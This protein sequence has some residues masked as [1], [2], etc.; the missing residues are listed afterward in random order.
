MKAANFIITERRRTIKILRRWLQAVDAEDAF[1]HLWLKFDSRGYEI[2]PDHPGV[3][4]WLFLAARSEAISILRK[5]VAR[6]EEYISDWIGLTNFSRLAEIAKNPR[7]GRRLLT[8]QAQERADREGHENFLE[9]TLQEIGELPPNYR[10][11]LLLILAGAEAGLS[12]SE[13]LDQAVRLTGLR[14]NT[15]SVHVYRARTKLRQAL[16]LSAK[17][18]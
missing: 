3:Y 8:E 12:E 9:K 11:A 1:Q 10:E 15:I 14:R 2:D 18:S 5:K 4:R 16:G 13:C 7:T 17:D 6:R